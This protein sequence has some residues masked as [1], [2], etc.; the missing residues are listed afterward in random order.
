MKAAAA[1]MAMAAAAQRAIALE[2]LNHALQP[3]DAKAITPIM[4][5]C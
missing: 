5:M 3:A 1:A 2:A 4:A